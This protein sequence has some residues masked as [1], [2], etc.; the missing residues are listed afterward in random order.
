MDN[1][2]AYNNQT[3]FMNWRA[4]VHSAGPYEID[5]ISTDTYGV[6]T[7]NVHSGAMRGYSSPQLI[8]AQEQFIE[9]LA[10]ACGMD[11]LEFRR[12]NLL[13]DG[14]LTATGVPVEHCVIREIMDATAEQTGY[15]EKHAAYLNQ[16]EGSRRRRGI[17]LAVCHRGSGLGAESPDA[18]GCM[19]IC[20]EDGSVMINSGLAENGQGLKTAYA[21]IA[22]EALGVSYDAVRFF[23]TDTH[24]IPDC[25]MTVA[26]RGTVMG[27]QS[28]I[29]P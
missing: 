7:N 13:H 12:K 19:M 29:R 5:N 22:A 4:N 2:G 15:K 28:V 3:Q 17:G 6:F 11:E 23:G 21:Q 9:E 10:M 27:A 24:T 8:W 18:S 16:P 14:A 26:S 25:G 1:C 20:N